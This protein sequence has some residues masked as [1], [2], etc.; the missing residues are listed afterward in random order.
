MPEET[1]NDVNQAP[2]EGTVMPSPAEGTPLPGQ[3]EPQAP[4]VEPEPTPAEGE[5]SA[6]EKV[7]PLAALHEERNKRQELQ[8]ELE[9]LKQIAGNNVLFDV[10]GKPVSNATPAPQDQPVARKAAEELEQLWESDPRKAVQVEIMAAMSW[11]DNMETR[12]DTQIS[13]ATQAH[14]DFSQYDGLVRQYIRA[15]PLEQRSKD[16]VVDLAYYVVKGQTS[17]SA[18]E[19]AKAEVLQKLKAGENVQGLQP[20]TRPAAPAP[21]GKE[22]TA[23]QSAV[24]EQMGLTPEQYQE[25]QVSK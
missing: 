12:V 8:S 18:V 21:K 4:A 2:P 23:E 22:M 16:G 1:P 9:A 6:E 5:P 11:R 15:L 7:V 25:G 13:D 3:P 10:N 20:G 24:A 14:P 17:T 19:R